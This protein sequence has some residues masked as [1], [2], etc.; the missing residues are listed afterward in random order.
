MIATL[1]QQIEDNNKRIMEIDRDRTAALLQS[2]AWQIAKD[3]G[4]D[5]TRDAMEEA[6]QILEHER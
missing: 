5:S 2:V 4:L 6:R 1:I 3:K